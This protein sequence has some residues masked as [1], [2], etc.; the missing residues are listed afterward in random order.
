MINPELFEIPAC[1]QMFGLHDINRYVTFVLHAILGKYDEANALMIFSGSAIRRGAEDFAAKY[2][3]PTVP[4][5]RGLLHDS[6]MPVPTVPRRLYLL[7]S[8][9]PDVARWFACPRSTVNASRARLNPKLRGH[10]A[11]LPAPQSRV[12]FHH[13][14]A[15]VLGVCSCLSLA[16]PPPGTERQIEWAL[17]TQ[18]LVITEPVDGLALECVGDLDAGTLESLESRLSMPEVV[19]KEAPGP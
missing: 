8:T 13:S 2:P 5:Y 9:D 12:L 1:A 14:W 16:P 3:F 7:W 11:E 18:R 19:S 10:I 4:I 15:K 17:R 6:A